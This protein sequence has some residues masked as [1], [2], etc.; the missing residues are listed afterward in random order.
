V[1][2]AAATVERTALAGHE[3]ALEALL[4]EY[5]T[6]VDRQARDYFGDRVDGLDVDEAVASD[7]A[8]LEAPALSEPL[9]V[10]S[11][12]D[13]LVGTVQAKRLDTANVEMK[14]LYVRPDTRGEGI[15]RALV[16]TFLDE[17]ATEGFETVRLGVAPYHDRAR[18]LYTD[19]GFEFTEQYEGS[20]APAAIVE[21]WG[22]M[23][24]SL[25]DW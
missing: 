24:R 4:T 25:S 14:R 23:Q 20:N 21:D 17:V 6:L 16:T 3:S 7:L 10:A 13:R 2:T 19:L 12:P 11:T 22:F 8:R 9:V 1:T 5:F 15:G 18:A